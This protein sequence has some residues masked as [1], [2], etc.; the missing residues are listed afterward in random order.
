MNKKGQHIF[1]GMMISVMVFIV[2]VQFLDPLKTQIETARDV[3][4]LDCGNSSISTGT[5]ATC[6]VV[7]WT[8]FY[9]TGISIAVGAG[10]ILGFGAKKVLG[11]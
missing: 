2:A 8:L 3:P 11:N 5:K 1:V 6:I 4:N 9:Y 7:D 10:V